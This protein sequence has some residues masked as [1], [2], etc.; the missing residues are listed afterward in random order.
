MCKSLN[1][2]QTQVYYSALCVLVAFVIAEGK[3]QRLAGC[4]GLPSAMTKAIQ[5]SHT[6]YLLLSH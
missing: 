4:R 6:E 5:T 3:L 1:F 2:I